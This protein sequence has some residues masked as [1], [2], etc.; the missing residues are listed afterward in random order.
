MIRL[1]SQ[2]IEWVHQA[3]GFGTMRSRQSLFSWENNQEIWIKTVR[4]SFICWYPKTFSSFE[5]EIE[6][7]HHIS[8]GRCAHSQS[9][10]GSWDNFLSLWEI[11][12]LSIISLKFW[13]IWI[14][15]IYYP[16]GPLNSIVLQEI[17]WAHHMAWGRW[18]HSQSSFSWENFLAC[19]ELSLCPTR[20]GNP[21]ATSWKNDYKERPNL[22]FT[23]RLP[24]RQFRSIVQ[25]NM[26]LCIMLL[27]HNKMQ[28]VPDSSIDKINHFDYWVRG[29]L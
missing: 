14:S 22:S 15:M 3:S 19:G 1:T 11:K 9:S 29:H 5:Q 2:E 28:T 12:D 24:N 13:M 16:S 25:Y 23:F 18:A 8:W 6:W 20:G 7:A 27:L 21:A 26:S 17:E 4:L 10:L